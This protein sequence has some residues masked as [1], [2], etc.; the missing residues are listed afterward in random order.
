VQVCRANAT[1]GSLHYERQGQG[2]PLVLLHGIGGELCVWEP[3]LEPLARHRDVIAVDLPGFGNSPALAPDVVPSPAALAAAVSGLLAELGI[4]RAHVA[5]NSLG[6]WVALEMARR[7]NARSVV[8]LCPAGL[9][10]APLQGAS[11]ATRGRAHRVVR[12]LR[13]LLWLLLRSRRARRVALRPFVADPDKVPYQAA[14]RMVRSYGRAAAY[15]AT[16]TAMRQSYFH[17]PDQIQVPVL[18]AFGEQDRLIRP[19]RVSAPS[20]R[21]VALPGCGHIPMWDDTALVS[22]VILQGRPSP[23][24]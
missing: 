1:Q 2:E 4:D 10:G 22:E 14:W 20:F 16:S 11:G 23:A 17:D 5:G 19:V 12:W 18:L 3:V 7:G 9:W 13:P 24:L 15:D 21:S 8:G 6:G